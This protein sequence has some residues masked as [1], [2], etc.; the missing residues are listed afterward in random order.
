MDFQ[1]RKKR[2]KREKRTNDDWQHLVDQS[3]WKD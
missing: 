3:N 2:K 1:G